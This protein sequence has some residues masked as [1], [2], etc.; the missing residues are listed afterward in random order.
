MVNSR[1]VIAVLMRCLWRAKVYLFVLL[2]ASSIFH[3]EVFAQI[4]AQPPMG[5]NSWNHFGS[6]ITD[7]DVRSVADAMAINGMREA[8]YK[9]INI[10]DGWQGGRDKE[11]KIFPNDRFPDMQSLSAYIHSKGFKLGIYSSPGEKSCA[12]FEGGMQ[13]ETQDAQTFASWGIDFL[14]YDICT[15]RKVLAA[16]APNDPE[17]AKHMMMQVFG[18]MADALAATGRPIVYSVSQHGMSEIW[19][20]GP[21]IHAN[22]WRVG[23]DVSDNYL[24]VTEI[25]FAQAGLASFAGPGHWNDPDMLE[26]GNKGL[27]ADEAKTQMSLWSLLAAPLLAGN[28]PDSTSAENLAILTNHE[29]IAIDQDAS[30][31]QGDRIWSQGPLEIW[32]RDLKDGGKAVGLFNRNASSANITLDPKRLGWSSA[33]QVHDVW[34][35]RDLEPLKYPKRFLVP[36]HGVL[37][38]LL[39]QA[40]TARKVDLPSVHAPLGNR[41]K[42]ELSS[43]P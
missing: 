21:Q 6:K 18:R 36:P 12:G 24:S 39:H 4:A 26:I 13:H 35:H 14:K 34:E 38:L 1:I 27:S 22:L 10:D 17:L 29:V 20:W 43:A 9:Y 30:G 32:E 8:G 15:Y 41:N 25:G 3:L 42:A 31:H 33:T 11:G 7:R 5:W 19:K 37:L 2:L 23:D 16:E 28:D 40:G